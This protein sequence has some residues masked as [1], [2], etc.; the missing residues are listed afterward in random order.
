MEARHEL[1]G[2]SHSAPALPA[3]GCGNWAIVA[4]LGN[5]LSEPV[6]STGRYF[7]CGWEWVLAGKNWPARESR[8]T[9][10]W[11][12]SEKLS[13]SLRP[14]FRCREGLGAG[15]TRARDPPGSLM[16]K[17]DSGVGQQGCTQDLTPFA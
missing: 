7:S 15:G 6:S 5:C 11:E 9:K 14:K 1:P 13:N 2:G 3:S 16:Q 4:F 17:Q 8:V 10:T 12:V